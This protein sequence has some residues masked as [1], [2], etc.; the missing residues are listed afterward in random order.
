MIETMCMTV[1]TMHDIQTMHDIYR[2]CMMS[3][4]CMLVETTYAGRD[5]AC[6]VST[7]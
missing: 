3:R 1:E 7:G 6:V 5:N 4:Q 2:Q